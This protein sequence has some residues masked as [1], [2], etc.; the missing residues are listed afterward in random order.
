MVFVGEMTN[1]PGMDERYALTGQVG[2][3]IAD[4]CGVDLAVFLRWRRF[5]LC[6]GKVW[7]DREAQESARRILAGA[8]PGDCVVLLGAR[9]RHAFNLDRM[10]VWSA[11]PSLIEGVVIATMP[12]P[13]GRARVWNDPTTFYTARRFLRPLIQ[14]YA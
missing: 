7:D 8:R 3:R 9:V 6:Q 14:E 5:N 13:S 12:H 4:L 11:A 2:R 10:P 1:P